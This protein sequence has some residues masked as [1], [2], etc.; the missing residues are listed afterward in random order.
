MGIETVSV[1]RQKPFVGFSALPVFA[2]FLST[3]HHSEKPACANEVSASK[4]A[5]KQFQCQCLV[6]HVSFST[7]PS[8]ILGMALPYPNGRKQHN[9]SKLFAKAGAVVPVLAFC[10]TDYK[11][12]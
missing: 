1:Q 7:F 8:A 10:C 6:P 4:Q 3:S 2:D 9:Y 11:R 5:S 12:P